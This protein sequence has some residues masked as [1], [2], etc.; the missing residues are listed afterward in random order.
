MV[1]WRADARPGHFCS[2]CP[3]PQPN[4]LELKSVAVKRRIRAGH[5]SGLVVRPLHS[6]MYCTTDGGDPTGDLWRLAASLGR[7]TSPIGDNLDLTS[8]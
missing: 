4:H 2:Q 3:A 7:G 5:H 1:W 8:R 6:S